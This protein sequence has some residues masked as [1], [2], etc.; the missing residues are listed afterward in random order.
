MPPFSIRSLVLR[1]P[2]DSS[3]SNVAHAPTADDSAAVAA[4]QAASFVVR[5]YFV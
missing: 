5:V 3:A 1:S 2:A 4:G